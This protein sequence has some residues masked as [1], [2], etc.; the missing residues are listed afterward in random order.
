MALGASPPPPPRQ[1]TQKKY[2]ERKKLG[3]EARGE[4]AAAE[5]GPAGAGVTWDLPMVGPGVPGLIAGWLLCCAAAQ[6]GLAAAYW[7]PMSLPKP[8]PAAACWPP[9]A[10]P[11]A[12][13]DWGCDGG[14]GGGALGLL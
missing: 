5:A 6:A 11:A 9:A 8:M 3:L 4:A 14:G 2:A 12:A 1:K 10:A 7:A 13:W